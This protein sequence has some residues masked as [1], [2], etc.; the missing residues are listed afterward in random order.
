M[1]RGEKSKYTGKQERKAD[2]I[3]EGYEKK[4]N[5]VPGRP[6]TKTM[7]AARKPEAR[8]GGN[9]PAT[10]LLER[11]V[12][13]EASRRRGSIGFYYELTRLWDVGSV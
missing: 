3:A 4:R 10:R 6:S 13:R 1:P 8:A 5:V 7:A 11:A 2:H 12:K 9:G